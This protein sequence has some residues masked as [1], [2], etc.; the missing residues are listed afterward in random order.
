VH[1]A[2]RNLTDQEYK[3]AVIVGKKLIGNDTCVSRATSK[4]ADIPE[5]LPLSPVERSPNHVAQDKKAHRDQY[6]VD[7]E[8]LER[9]E[10]WRDNPSVDPETQAAIVLEYRALH[11]QF[12]SQGHMPGSPCVT[13]RFSQLLATSFT[14]S[15]TSHQPCS[16]DFSGYVLAPLSIVKRCL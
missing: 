8:Q 15:G 16:L 12:K 7:Q 14:S 9:E 2:S 5:N 11:E 3:A 13:L 6:A 4:P 1:A 10:G